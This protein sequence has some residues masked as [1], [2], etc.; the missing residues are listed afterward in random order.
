MKNGRFPTTTFALG[1]GR[2]PT[3]PSPFTKTSTDQPTLNCQSFGFDQ[4]AGSGLA[5]IGPGARRAE[6]AGQSKAWA[7]KHGAIS[8]RRPQRH[9][10]ITDQARLWCDVSSLLAQHTKAAPRLAVAQGV[11]QWTK[12]FFPDASGLTNLVLNM[13][14]AHFDAGKPFPDRLVASRDGW[15]S[16]R[17]FPNQRLNHSPKP[18]PTFAK[19]ICCD[20]S[21]SPRLNLK[22]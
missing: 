14:T 22:K 12:T 19:K 6:F 8:D 10:D 20:R 1:N 15:G 4:S 16:E 7:R 21:P 17:P 3:S 2:S 5:L 9:S 13:R 18:T 11:C